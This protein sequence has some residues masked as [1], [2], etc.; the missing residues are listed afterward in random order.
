MREAGSL[1][2]LHPHEVAQRQRGVLVAALRSIF[3]AAF[4]IVAVLAMLGGEGSGERIPLV[5]GWYLILGFAIVL[6]LVT[7]LIDW[8]TPNKKIS[9]IASVFFGIMVAMLA[10]FVAGQFIDLIASLY[11]IQYA[12]L[13]STAKILVGIA[14]AYLGVVTVLQTQDDFRLVIP[15]VEFAKQIRGTRPYLLD[16]SA[17][18][19]ARILDIGETGLIQ[20]PLIIPEF[21]VRELQALADSKDRLKRERGR[22]G[23]EV[24]GKLQRSPSLDVTIDDTPVA[25]KA[26]DQML[27]SLASSMPAVIITTD[28]GLT[29][30]ARIQGVKVLN[31]ND[32]A[33][34]MKPSLVQGERF[35]IRLVKPGE[36]KGQGVGYLEDG[37]MVVAEDGER[38]IGRTV[39]LTVTNIVQTSAGRLIFGRIDEA[40]DDSDASGPD[41][42]DAREAPADTP[43]LAKQSESAGDRLGQRGTGD[44]DRPLPRRG[45]E[46]RPRS[47]RNPRR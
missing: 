34:A 38:A 47:P 1:E 28:H 31:L 25:G 33:G 22:R 36:Q 2:D 8:L 43:S 17:L 12:Q 46:E 41:D 10:T 20:A 24:I 45:P 37:T 40:T 27:V 5:E 6:A 13:I 26:V 35:R 11:D 21:V 23:L 18:I 30:V 14:L 19:D 39:T 42:A 29:R 3:L 4:I 9:T 32:L 44:R 15:Y 7:A 16:T